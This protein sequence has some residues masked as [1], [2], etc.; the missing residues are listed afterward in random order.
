MID[1]AVL[2]A[3]PIIHLDQIGRLYVLEVI[4]NKATTEEVKKEVGQEVVE[5]SGLS[6]LELSP[7][8]KDRAKHLSN[9]YGIELG[10]ST[11]ISLCVQED[12]DLIFTDD[13][14]ARDAAERFQIDAHGTLALVSR[15]Y[16]EDILSQAEALEA[17]EELR[18]DSSLFLTS[19]LVKWAKERIREE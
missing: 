3:G 11:S 15:A 9:K 19:D 10:E 4:E 17:I 18:K 2:D 8:S 13:L 5:K 12:I 7:E 6:V 16:S 1:E 14:D